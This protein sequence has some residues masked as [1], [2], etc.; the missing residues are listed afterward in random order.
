MYVLM[1]YIVLMLI[2]PK[3]T[4]II[5][6]LIFFNCIY[7]LAC[8][9]VGAI[10]PILAL[11]AVLY[12]SCIIKE[13]HHLQKIKFFHKFELLCTKLTWKWNFLK[14]LSMPDFPCL[15]LLFEGT[16][17]LFNSVLIML[18][19]PIF[20]ITGLYLIFVIVSEL[21]NQL[22]HQNISVDKQLGLHHI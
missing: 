4:K 1:S 13:V 7:W 8:Q 17:F 2:L 18:F 9:T 16:I 10:I 14:S 15:R 20:Y 21:N 11:N 5:T 6:S 19:G 3:S 12:I 22:F